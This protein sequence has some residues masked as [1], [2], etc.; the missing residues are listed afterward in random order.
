MWGTL[1][2]AGISAIGSL[3]GGSMSS[4]GAAQANNQSAMYNA[5]E[6]QKNRD[7]QERMA[8]TAYQRAMGDMKA[9][10]LNPILAYQQGGAGIGSGAQASMKF[11]NA[12]EGLG[13]GVTSAAK[14]A[15]RAIQLQNVSSQTANNKAQEAVRQEEVGLT[16]A[17]AQ[18]SVQNAV[19]S[20]KQAENINADTELKIQSSGNPAAMRKQMEASAY[21]STA[22]GDYIKQ[23]QHLER[24][25]ATTMGRAI[26]S[27]IQ[28]YRDADNALTKHF[29]DNPIYLPG[30]GP[31]GSGSHSR[32]LEI[33]MHKN[34]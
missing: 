2:A 8:N 24:Y 10:G 11:E 25:G 27:G 20:A 4:A 32:P 7:W 9:A 17:K 22:Y 14:G 1:G 28:L 18:E 23:K 19:T 29:N 16:R 6:A 3:I 33:N 21:N 12:M 15:E 30:T 13:Q 26:T 5:M 31:G 34:R